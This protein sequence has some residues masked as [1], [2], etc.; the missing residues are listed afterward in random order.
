M[1]SDASLM[2]VGCKQAG[3]PNMCSVF[4]YPYCYEHIETKISQHHGHTQQPL[5]GVYDH[6]LPTHGDLSQFQSGSIHW[7][8]DVT[9]QIHPFVHLKVFIN[10]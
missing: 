2:S 6:L 1:D 7:N 9:L 10:C 8:I 5:Q 3:C 4:V